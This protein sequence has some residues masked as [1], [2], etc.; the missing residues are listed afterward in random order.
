[1]KDFQKIKNDLERHWMPTLVPHMHVHLNT[2]TCTHIQ[3]AHTQQKSSSSD[4]KIVLTMFFSDT[5]FTSDFLCAE[6]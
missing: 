1:M 6:F 4:V 2:H 5:D 3:H